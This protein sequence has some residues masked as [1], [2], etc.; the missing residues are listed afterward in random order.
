MWPLQQLCGMASDVL[1]PIAAPRSDNSPDASLH[2]HLQPGTP[3]VIDTATAAQKHAAVSDAVQQ[4]PASKSHT[5]M[6]GIA[7]QP[8]I[9]AASATAPSEDAISCDAAVLVPHS[10]VSARQSEADSGFR[11]AAAQLIPAPAAP[12]PAASAPNRLP[13]LPPKQQWSA[14]QQP[15]RQRHQ[16]QAS[17]VSAQPQAASTTFP[18]AVTAT[19]AAASAAEV[20]Q[21]ASLAATAS[22]LSRASVPPDA[23]AAPPAAP[24]WLL[25]AAQ[26]AA[27]EAMAAAAAARS[28]AAHL[29]ASAAAAPSAAA[30]EQAPGHKQCLACHSVKPAAQFEF[31]NAPPS[32][33]H[34]VCSNCKRQLHIA[35][36]SGHPQ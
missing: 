35:A 10:N 32:F 29:A 33:L 3:A 36:P 1:A 25:A 9:P 8:A 6:L 4:P 12:V 15:Q 16:Q 21:L 18:A 26:L 2:A 24:S 31:A 19:H 5:D 27:P 13:A 30:P 14:R 34:S 17:N 23:A 28:V 22:A 20:A 11:K 7:A